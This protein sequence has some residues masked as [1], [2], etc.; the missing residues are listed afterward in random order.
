MVLRLRGRC[1][2]KV[3]LTVLDGVVAPILE[4]ISESEFVFGE[5]APAAGGNYEREAGPYGVLASHARRP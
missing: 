1:R 3:P 4:Q 5:D 2:A